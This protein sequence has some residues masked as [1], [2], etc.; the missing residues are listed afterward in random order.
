MRT[1]ALV[2]LHSDLWS[3]KTM[4]WRPD[5]QLLDFKRQDTRAQV[6]F[7]LTDHALWPIYPRT[8][9]SVSYLTLPWS[10]WLKKAQ[11]RQFPWPSLCSRKAPMPWY[12]ASIWMANSPWSVGIYRLQASHREVMI[13]W[14]YSRIR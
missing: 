6:S 10:F 4:T 8:F 13:F 1:R 3:V 11:G 7:S 14:K 2:R 5:I 9:T 12:G